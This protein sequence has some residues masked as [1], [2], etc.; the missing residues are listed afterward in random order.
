MQHII[1]HGKRAEETWRLLLQAWQ[2]NVS[3]EIA[4]F[5]LQDE[6]LYAQ[7]AIVFYTKEHETAHNGV[8][9]VFLT[10]GVDW[11]PLETICKPAC[12]HAQASQ[13]PLACA[14][15]RSGPEP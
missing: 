7:K 5:T 11:G 15:D 2:W 13:A 1:D 6:R 14:M 9:R 12:T 3:R 4:A 8:T 10:I